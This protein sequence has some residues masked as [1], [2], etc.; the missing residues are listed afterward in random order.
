MTGR[1][2]GLRVTLVL[3]LLA[4][5]LA[6]KSYRIGCLETGSASEHAEAWEA[7][8][9]GLRELGYVEDQNITLEFRFAQGRPDRLPGLAAE[10]ARLRVDAIV[11][12]SNAGGLAAKH[13]TRTIPVVMAASGDPVRAGVVDSLARPGGNV[14]GLTL[15]STEVS[16][17]RLQLLKEVAPK[18]TRVAVIWNGANPAGRDSL[19]ETE[20]AARAL[21]L[22]LQAVEVRTPG[23]LDAAF[24]SVLTARPSAFI[25]LPDGMLWTNR[26]RIADFAAR[27]RL[28][29]VFDER[30]FAEAGGLMA[31]GPSLAS[32]FRRAAALVD[33][34]LTGTRPA[35]LPVEQPTRLE[36]VINLKTARALGLTV[37][38]SVLLR[39][40]RVIE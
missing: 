30:A 25:T 31:Y 19:R 10:L 4:A 6:A 15:L 12:E 16:A 11:T 24:A 7:F 33:R 5:P 37:P 32:N 9:R 1:R 29:G 26:A 39:A 23:D 35:E 38:R 27:S 8:R 40:D 2:L 21:G 28:P 36:M 14:T 22:R 20:A 18:T 17:K 3:G 34:I 13:A